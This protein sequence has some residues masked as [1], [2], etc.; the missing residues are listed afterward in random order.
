MVT[1]MEVYAPTTGASDEEIGD[2][3]EDLSRAV[4]QVAIDTRNPS[5]LTALVGP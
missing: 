5:T 3:Y 1:L 4:K 2:F